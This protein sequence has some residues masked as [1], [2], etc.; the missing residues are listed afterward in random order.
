MER[1]ARGERGA[2][3]G[4]EPEQGKEGGKGMG[5]GKRSG[6]GKRGKEATRAGRFLF[7]RFPGYENG[8]VGASK[9][10]EP[11]RSKSR[12]AAAAVRSCDSEAT[13]SGPEVTRG[14][15]R[16]NRIRSFR[17]LFTSRDEKRGRR[18]SLALSVSPSRRPSDTLDRSGV[19]SSYEA[20]DATD[21]MTGC[22]G[23]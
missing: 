8:Q 16:G 9:A 22:G 1:A 12:D 3:V 21:R 17:S 20:F 19:G 18:R 5:N 4:H 6:M 11:M 23:R 2:R 7:R 14:G 10:T 13:Q 15:S